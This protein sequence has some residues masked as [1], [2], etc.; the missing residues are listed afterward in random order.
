MRK[1]TIQV[2]V[3]GAIVGE[4]HELTITNVATF[5]EDAFSTPHTLEEFLTDLMIETEATKSVWRGHQNT[6]YYGHREL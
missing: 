3:D 1:Y 2:N 6:V 4:F 5:L